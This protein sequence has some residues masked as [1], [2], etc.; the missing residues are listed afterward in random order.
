MDTERCSGAIEIIMADPTAVSGE[1][2][3]AQAPLRM[4]L[5]RFSAERLALC[6][7]WFNAVETTDEWDDK[8]AISSGES[9]AIWVSRRTDGLRGAAKPGEPKADSV[10][11][12]AHEKIAF[13]LAHQLDFPVPPVILWDRGDGHAAN[14]HLAISAWAYTQCVNWDAACSKGA[15]SDSDKASTSETC[16]AMRVFHTWIGD[17]DRK[18]EHV[19]VD[20]SSPDGEL[21]I[22]FI[23]HA[24]SMSYQWKAPDAA[25][26]PSPHYMPLQEHREAMLEAIQRIEALSDDEIKRIVE[27]IPATYLPAHE[28]GNIITNLISR[29]TKLCEVLGLQ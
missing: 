22:A 16:S 23:D 29:K 7:E 20:E 10:C 15:I 6:S 24:F 17:C 26:Q 2:P 5:R 11:R 4:T 21:S 9:K 12:A 27:R 18:T 19:Q 3:A 25:I 1:N 14:R 8:G 28:K 13:D